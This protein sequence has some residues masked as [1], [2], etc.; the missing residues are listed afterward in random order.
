MLRS[1]AINGESNVELKDRGVNYYKEHDTV[2]GVNKVNGDIN[3]GENL[4]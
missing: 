2:G 1:R 3:H 4:D